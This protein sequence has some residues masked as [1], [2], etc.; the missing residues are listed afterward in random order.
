MGHVDHSSALVW[1]RMQRPGSYELSWAGGRSVVEVGPESDLCCSFPLTGL[2][3]ESDVA[4]SV[5]RTGEEP[6]LASGRLHT[7]P[8]PASRAPVRLVFGS[9]ANDLKRPQQPIWGQIRRAA[10]DALIL[11]G[12]TPYIDSTELEVQR[13]RYREFFS[14]P[15][16]APALAEIS[17][18]AT[19][20]DHD[21]GR[22]DTDG[23]LP[24]KENSRRAF[25]EYHANP[26]AGQGGAGIYTSFR[27]GPVEVFLLDTRWFAGTEPSFVDAERPTLLG[28][29][30]WAWL[31]RELRSSD[32]PF[33]VLACGMIWNGATRPGKT[34]HWGNYAHERE[35]LFRWLGQQQISGVVL[36][37]GDI[38]RTRVVR[39]AVGELAGE[40]L[41]EW[42]TSPLAYN[43]IKAANAPHPGLLYDG[44]LT[45][46]CLVFDIDAT[47]EEAVL[48]GRIIDPA[49]KVH[50][51]LQ[52]RAPL[53][54]TSGD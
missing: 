6:A 36:V 10:P 14:Q 46:T 42:I 8:K 11:L 44:G 17:T 21:F 16:V 25:L 18:Y 29:Q 2:E 23:L 28:E 32:A 52:Q 35:A 15:Q 26:S 27:R 39:H 51:S 47:A 50:F 43:V 19:W 54:G 37:G 12:D 13:R 1:M 4:F 45:D 5:H 48:I 33:K 53:A 38:H 24:G 31:R 34:D 22:N 20:D 49:G 9:C 41:V 40:D 30:Q 7:G 3:P